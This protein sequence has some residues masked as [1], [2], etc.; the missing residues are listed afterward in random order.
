MQGTHLGTSATPRCPGSSRVPVLLGFGIGHPSLWVLTA[1]ATFDELM[2]FHAIS[3]LPGR[4]GATF[5]AQVKLVGL[6]LA[7]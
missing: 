3:Y 6:G 5:S 2:G 4:G 7:T 1:G